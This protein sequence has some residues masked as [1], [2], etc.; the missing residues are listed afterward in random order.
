MKKLAFIAKTLLVA[1]LLGGMTACGNSSEEAADAKAAAPAPAKS[2]KTL[3]NIR[4]I[5]GDSVSANYNLAKDFQE[6]TLRQM[7]AIDNARQ[8]R[9]N[10]IQKLAASI[11]QK[12]RSNGYLTQ[13]SY[14]ADMQQLQKKQQDAERVLGD[15]QRKLEQDML[16][17]Q[18]AMND[19]IEAFIKIYNKK[20]GYDAILFKAA[21]VYF[22]PELDITNEVIEG[23]NARYNKK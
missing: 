2:A 14:Q 6:T 17:Q 12:G 16:A 10:E 22:N 3:P 5:D 11:E 13:E 19:S 21:G 4:Y 9:A 8:Q 18:T 20:K 7:S 23:L 15:M 1:A